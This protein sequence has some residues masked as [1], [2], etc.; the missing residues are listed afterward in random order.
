MGT[1]GLQSTLW[2]IYLTLVVGS[3]TQSV[4]ANH[5]GQVCTTWGEYHWK[6]FDGNFFQLASSCNHVV[7][8]QCKES[9]EHFNIQ[10][11]RTLVKDVLSIST[12]LL[13][14]EGTV[15]EI[16]KTSVIVDEKT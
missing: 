9:Y 8:S 2:I 3:L 13:T 15:V 10:M 5:I 11:R 12:I 4:D 1:I 6:T 16:S 14:F 7:A